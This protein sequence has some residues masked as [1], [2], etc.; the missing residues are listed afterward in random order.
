MLRV[1]ELERRDCPAF[2][3]LSYALGLY[4]QLPD[5]VHQTVTL[6]GCDYR[7]D[8]RPI[9]NAHLTDNAELA[10]LAGTSTYWASGTMTRSPWTGRL[11]VYYLV[12]VCTTPTAVDSLLGHE[13]QHWFSYCYRDVYYG[14]RVSDS[15]WW[16]SVWESLGRPF[17]DRE[18]AFAIYG[19]L[20]LDRSDSYGFVPALDAWFAALYGPPDTV[21]V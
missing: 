3:H 1:E 14:N 4:A 17:G 21:G 10:H 15:T 9:W 5:V 13:Y 20:Y 2:D 6:A 18:E 8:V 19:Q 11:T 12:D 7:A 16:V